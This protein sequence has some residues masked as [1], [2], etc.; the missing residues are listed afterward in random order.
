MR[1]TNIHFI[2]VLMTVT[3]QDT[4]RLIKLRA[5]NE[6]LFTG[7]RN[8]AKTAWKAIL[9]ELGLLGK[10]ST[11]QV[12]KKWDN[13]KRR[14]KDLKYPP[15]GMESMADNAASWP[16]FYLMNEAM[17][18]R[19]A[20]SGPVLTPITEGDDPKPSPSQPI[21]SRGRP[22]LDMG[23]TTLEYDQ[24]MYADPATEEC[25]RA[26]AE[27]ERALREERLGRGPREW[28]MVERARAA[29]E[30]DRAAVDRERQWLE[31]ERANLAR[32]RMLLEQDRMALG[33]EREVFESQRAAVV[34]NSATGVTDCS[35]CCHFIG[36]RLISKLNGLF[37]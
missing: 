33:R 21:R 19:L 32:E 8:A 13:L 11:Y 15:V 17:E 35:A 23:D 2:F 16:W 22:L 14:Y 26:T 12:A 27:C 5:A 10:V 6:V 28:E 34:M 7:R 37:N 30:G 1:L 9:K 36:S 24:E 4:R 29:I 18:G 31:S 25:H 20:A 3:E